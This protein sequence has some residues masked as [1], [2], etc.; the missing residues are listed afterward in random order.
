MSVVEIPLDSEEPDIPEI[1]EKEIVSEEIPEDEPEEKEIPQQEEPAAEISESPPS[2]TAKKICKTQG[3]CGSTSQ[4]IEK[5]TCAEE[6][7]KA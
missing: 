4:K 7:A 5:R 6:E 1:P 2:G 3:S